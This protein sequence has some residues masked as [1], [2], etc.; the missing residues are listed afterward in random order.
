MVTAGLGSKY[1]SAY[2]T[3]FY[4]KEF[5]SRLHLSKTKTT[6]NRGLYKFFEW[7]YFLRLEIEGT[8]LQI[9]K[10]LI[11][12]PFLVSKVLSKFPSSLPANLFTKKRKTKYCFKIF[13]NDLG[14]G[15]KIS[16][17]NH[18]YLCCELCVKFA[19][20]FKSS[21]LFNSFYCLSWL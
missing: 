10:A 1:V 15:W 16:H 4:W 7:I 18:L 8:V 20:F 3:S 11:N 14:L 5:S 2:D 21:L 13:K 9:E 19:V 12:D 17:F 6:L